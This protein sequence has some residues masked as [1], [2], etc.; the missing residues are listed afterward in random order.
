MIIGGN[1]MK[2]LGYSEYV[3]ICENREIDNAIATLK[4]INQQS[5]ETSEHKPT[6]INQ[7]NTQE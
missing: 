7:E 4:Q 5:E 3:Q 6:P 1:I 2:K